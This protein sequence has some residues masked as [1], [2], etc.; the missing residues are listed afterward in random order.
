MFLVGSL[1]DLWKPY[2]LSWIKTKKY[3]SNEAVDVAVPE[4]MWEDDWLKEVS[5]FDDELFARGEPLNNVGVVLV[6]GKL[7]SYADD[8]EAFL[9]KIGDGGFC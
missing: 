6:L 7:K 3:L 8:F 9:D 2:M 4:V 5:V 1:R